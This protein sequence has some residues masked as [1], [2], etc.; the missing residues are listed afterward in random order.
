MS[1][2]LYTLLTLAWLAVV[3]SS[4]ALLLPLDWV[5]QVLRQNL[6]WT[7]IVVVETFSTCSASP[8]LTAFESVSV[9]EHCPP[10][11]HVA[12]Q[13]SAL[14]GIGAV[15]KPGTTY[16][17]TESSVSTSARPVLVTRA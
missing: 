13:F 15:A 17:G 7:F 5:V 4:M 9:R 11:V 10:T 8:I 14:I 6:L 2:A 12:T 1:P 3:A 16:F